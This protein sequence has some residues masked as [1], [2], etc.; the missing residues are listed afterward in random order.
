MKLKHSYSDLIFDKKI[1]IIGLMPPPLGGISVHIKRVIKKFC[2]Q[3]N[4]VVSIDV[5]KESKN[6]SKI[7]YFLFLY[8]FLFKFKPDII[9]YHTL[10]L[11]KYPFELIILI[12][13]KFIFKAR[14]ILVDHT[15]RFFYDKKWLYKKN[16]NFLMRFVDKQILI[17]DSTFKSYL[18]NNI[19]LKNINIESSYLHPDLSEEK[20]I[21]AQYPDLLKK[22]LKSYSPVILINASQFKIWQNTD[23]YGID[24]AIQLINDLKVEFVD[25]G[26]IIAVSSLGDEDYFNKISKIIE[27]N[28]N[29]YLLFK[30]EHEI[31]PLMKY[32][33]IF[34]RPTC[35]DSY[36]ISVAESLFVGTPVVASD[37]CNRTK[38]AV[39]FKSRNQQD[40]N[41]K[42]T[43][44][45]RE[46][47]NDKDIG[48]YCDSYM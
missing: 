3:G 21:F 36:G 38:G 4:K 2:D 31:W 41:N 33:N 13:F 39:I 26:L 27:N 16:I 42:V 12:F 22:F 32:C 10:S 8:N 9:Y 25:I 48:K 34:I 45:L 6:R 15:A 5:V 43:T 46:I 30:C 28:N 18:E 40:L 29:I 37:V 14:L 19:Y 44:V 47:K 7:N 20:L 23:L 17:G 35:S 11:R 24:M 1:V